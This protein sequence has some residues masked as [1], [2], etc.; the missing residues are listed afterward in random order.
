MRFRCNKQELNR[1]LNIVSKAVS[2]RT[3]IPTLKG[4]LLEVK[5]NGKLTLT[6]SDM[7]ITIENTISVEG[8][9][10]G[11]VV[12][13]AK[14]FTDIVRKLPNDEIIVV[15][16]GEN[17]NISCLSS[18]F[19]LL[20]TSADEFP[21][22]KNTE[23]DSKELIF[24]K[25]MF[26]DMIKKTSFAASVD[27]T[28]GVITGILVE[29]MSENLRM[30]AIDGYRMAIS[31]EE[32]VNMEE[33]KVIISARI[34]NEINKI[35]T[36]TNNGEAGDIKLV[37]DN[38]SAVIYLD[39]IKVVLRLI[40][41][42]FIKYEDII[43]KDSTI[44]LLVRKG[45]LA[46]AVER[47][48]LLSKE[49]KN[50]LV[51]LSIGDNTLNITSRSEEGNVKEEVLI[52]KEGDDLEIGFNAKYILDILRAIE[53]EEIEMWF[54]SSISPCLVKPTEGNRYE[55]LILPVRIT[56]M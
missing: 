32:V 34:M 43:P 36:E 41:G 1:A 38:K 12:V 5:E 48:S 35:I 42:E 44:K 25:C 26:S 33:N 18:E 37:C 55:Y 8:T 2:T 17:I 29:L 9:E 56:N 46:E 11:A 16:E 40:A 14:L 19:T 21:N 28:K 30:V 24:D 53:D 45:D 31:T 27:Q 39:D 13:P 50:N 23:T 10:M 52:R 7:D 15:S 4:I 22:I 6:A 20:G 49:G 47:A 51:K 54:N 3:T